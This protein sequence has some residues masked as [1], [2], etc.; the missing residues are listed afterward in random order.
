MLPKYWPLSEQY[1][2][3]LKLKLTGLILTTLCSAPGLIHKKVFIQISGIE[4]HNISPWTVVWQKSIN[5]IAYSIKLYFCT[6]Q[7]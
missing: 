6:V 1:I 4:K 7:E 3:E 2:S 5:C